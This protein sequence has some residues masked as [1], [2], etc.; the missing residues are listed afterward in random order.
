MGKK[1]VAFVLLLIFCGCKKDKELIYECT[2]D[3]NNGE[4]GKIIEHRIVMIVTSDYK[5]FI[6]QINYTIYDISDEDNPD[7]LYESMIKDYEEFD[8]SV[9]YSIELSENK[10]IVIEKFGASEASREII[11]YAIDFYEKQGYV[12]GI[13]E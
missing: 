9:D 8:S 12:C 10:I 5:K 2:L 1:V 13:K 3:A 7:E 11:D 6:N 4:Y